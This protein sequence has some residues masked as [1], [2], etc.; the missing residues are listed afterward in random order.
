MARARSSPSEGSRKAPSRF[1][2]DAIQADYEEMQRRAADF[3]AENKPEDADKL[4]SDFDRSQ[5][6]RA[7]RAT[8][9]ANPTKATETASGAADPD[10]ARLFLLCLGLQVRDGMP[11]RP[12]VRDFLGDALRA[13]AID[14]TKGLDM[15]GLSWPKHRPQVN[16]ERDYA[17]AHRVLRLSSLHPINRSSN[18]QSAL[19]IAA[20]E[21]GVSVDVAELAWKKHG[22]NAKSWAKAM[23]AAKGKKSA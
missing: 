18:G 23:A 22:A 16:Q 15:F 13:L 2:A 19:E 6:F 7:L 4:L 14:P 12:E 21:H 8:A 10:D 3:R 5:V 9:R 17:I 1:D 20:A 11:L